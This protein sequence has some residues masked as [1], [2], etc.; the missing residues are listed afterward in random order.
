LVSINENGLQPV[1]RS[2]V[3]LTIDI[4]RLR[5]AYDMIHQ[6]IEHGFV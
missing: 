6:S 3:E 5:E 4:R 1:A 2:L